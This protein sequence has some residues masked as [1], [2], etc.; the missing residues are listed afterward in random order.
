[1]IFRLFSVNKLQLSR[2]VETNFFLIFY[3]KC[4]VK[5]GKR[6]SFV[7]YSI[8]LLTIQNRF[9]QKKLLKFRQIY[10]VTRK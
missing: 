4:I 10:I 6:K 2:F 9:K 7:L 5:F 1:M 3:I 8:L